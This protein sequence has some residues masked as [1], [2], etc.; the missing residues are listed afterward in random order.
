MDLHLIAFSPVYNILDKSQSDIF[1]I[2]NWSH[3]APHLV[4]VVLFVGATLYKKTL[5]LRM[6]LQTGSG[7]NLA[8]RNVLQ[9]NTRRL[10]FDLTSH[11]QD[12]GRDVIHTK[13]CCHLA[14]E[15]EASAGAYAAA[16]ASSWSIVHSYFFALR[17]HIIA[18]YALLLLSHIRYLCVLLIIIID[19]ILHISGQSL[20]Y[21][22]WFLCRQTWAVAA[23]LRAVRL[24]GLR[25]PLAASLYNKTA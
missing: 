13:K 4:V 24:A 16:S 7:W 15:H 2:R 6:S 22:A 14:S 18:I 5:S 9:V 10:I 1:L 11:I 8:G 20:T 19:I 25:S 12:G 23:T 17:S 3:I 21:L